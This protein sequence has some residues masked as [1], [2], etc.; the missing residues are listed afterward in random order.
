MTRLDER[1][2]ATLFRDEKGPTG[3]QA[4]LNLL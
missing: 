3:R 1:L 4:E 2:A